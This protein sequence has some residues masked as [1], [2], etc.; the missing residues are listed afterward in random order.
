[1]SPFR[2][3]VELSNCVSARRVLGILVICVVIYA[4]IIAIVLKLHHPVY[5]TNDRNQTVPLN[6]SFPKFNL[7]IMS[8]GKLG[9][10]M[11]EYAS[12][13]GIAHMNNRAAFFP[14]QSPLVRVFSRI[15]HLLDDATMQPPQYEIVYENNFATYDPKFENLPAKNVYLLQ[16][17]QSWKYFYKIED[18]IRKEYTFKQGIRLSAATMLNDLVQGRGNKTKIGVHV[19]RGDMLL[20]NHIRK[21]Y[22]TAPTSYIFNALNYMREKYRDAVFIVVTDDFAWCKST[23]TSPDVVVSGFADD[24]VH[25]ALLALCDHV[26]M[27]VG[28]YGWW[29]GYLSGGDVV[30]YYNLTENPSQVDIISPEDHFP[31]HWIRLGS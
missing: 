9:N 14:T 10:V 20:N 31:P 27:T 2:N 11:F 30:Y 1:M 7:T 3:L 8:T 6:A 23:L 25:L 15:S 5:R 19:R 18:Q 4:I 28:T 26:I 12:L 22:K 21:G 16:Y 17:F 13:L 29:G 24:A